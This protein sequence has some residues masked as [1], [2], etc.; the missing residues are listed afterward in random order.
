[1][2]NEDEADSPELSEVFKGLL[3]ISARR[4]A[5]I[6]PEQAARKAQIDQQCCF[7]PVKRFV[8]IRRATQVGDRANKNMGKNASPPVAFNGV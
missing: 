8:S 1:M 3:Q 4:K 7:M 6:I 5:V 2:G